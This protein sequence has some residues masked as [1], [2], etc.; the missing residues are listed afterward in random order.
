MTMSSASFSSELT[1]TLKENSFGL[2]EYQVIRETQLESTATVV[3]LEGHAIT[4]S[5]SPRGFEVRRFS[6]HP[7]LFL[8]PASAT[9][10]TRSWKRK[11]GSFTRRSNSC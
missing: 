1:S 10:K 9:G 6:D 3:L 5:L 7:H 8:S 2:K 4:V 11:P